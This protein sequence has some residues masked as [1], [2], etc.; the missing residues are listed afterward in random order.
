MTDIIRAAVPLLYPVGLIWFILIV[1][2]FILLKK[3]QWLLAMGCFLLA[4][5]WSVL[6][7]TKVPFTLL[8]TLE[9]PFA[10]NAASNIAPADAVV[11]LGGTVIPSSFDPAGF[12]LMDPADRPFTGIELLRNKK[13]RYLVLGGGGG[14]G[15]GE[16]ELLKK[17][18]VMTGMPRDVVIPLGVSRNTYD[19]ARQTQA[20]MKEKGW[21]RVILV[22]SA[23]HMR[24]AL[25]CFQSFGIDAEPVAC[26]FVALSTLQRGIPLM[27]IPELDGFIAIEVYLHEV[28][29]WHY[30]KWNGW[31]KDPK[32]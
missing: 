18:A 9:R 31:I 3:R 22:T 29:G 28:I 12:Q 32:E 11:V 20:L 10:T 1:A 14:A 2:G 30:Y 19:E 24:R 5:G 23:S 17:W 4:V 15:W 25:A 13:A 27:V 6:G 21:N 8:A 7:S 26:D 16:P